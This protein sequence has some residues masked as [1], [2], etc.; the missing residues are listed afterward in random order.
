M[1]GPLLSSLSSPIFHTSSKAP[2]QVS[3]HIHVIS[4]T[5]SQPS[6]R[7]LIGELD[8]LKEKKFLT[9]SQ[10]ECFYFNEKV[11]ELSFVS[12]TKLTPPTGN[13]IITNMSKVDK[14]SAITCW[15]F[16]YISFNRRL[17]AWCLVWISTRAHLQKLV[18]SKKHEISS[19]L[20]GTSFARNLSI[21]CHFL[22]EFNN[23]LKDTL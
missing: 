12:V 3:R 15:H 16:V 9:K 14:L 21:G 19:L 8:L 10:T 7:C 4:P 1:N 23:D 5:N 20:T 17:L 11:F 22:F 2:E 6:H 18:E 13:L